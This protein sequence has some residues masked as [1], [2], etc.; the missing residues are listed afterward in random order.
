MIKKK[1]CLIGSFAVGK[2][3]LTRRFV[4]DEFSDDYLTTLGV[5]I[6]RRDVDLDGTTVGLMIWDLAGRDEFS[7]VQKSYLVGA[8]GLLFVADGTRRETVEE[9]LEE[10]DSVR[11]A[12]GNDVPAVVLLNKADLVEEWELDSAQVEE[13]AESFTVFT[14]SALTG[15][16][17]DDA[18]TALSREMLTTRA[19]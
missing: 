19:S 9:M 14:T 15:E 2:T 11:Q 16:H 5:K 8:S 7:R 18:F 4:S 6:E 10:V 17:V 3:S 12:L 13:L 1:I